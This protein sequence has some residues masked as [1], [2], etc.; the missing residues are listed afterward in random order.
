MG[1][2]VTGWNKNKKLKVVAELIEKWENGFM[3]KG[4]RVI[5]VESK[6]LKVL[7]RC[8]TTFSFICRQ[9]KE[10]KVKINR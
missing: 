5:K 6:M 9:T 8:L 3:I 4:F 1:S 10:K 2:G 7:K